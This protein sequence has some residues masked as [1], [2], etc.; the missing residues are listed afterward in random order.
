MSLENRLIDYHGWR[1]LAITNGI[2]E[3]IIPLEVGLRVMHFGFVG[4][5]NQFATFP[6]QLGQKGGEAWR[7]YGGHRLWH[8]PEHRQR[9]YSNDNHPISVGYH[10]DFWRLTQAADHVGIE[11]QMDFIP[12]HDRARV[13]VV[14]RLINR[15]AW[16]V[17]LAVWALSVMNAG[18]T[19]V[20]PLPPYGSHESNLLPKG[21]I[22]L[23][24][25]TDLADPRY[26]WGSRYALIRQERSATTPQKVGFASPQ[27]WLGYVND[28][29]LFVKHA[30]VQANAPY[31]D[32]G[33]AQEVFTDHTILELE[34]LAPLVALEPNSAT[35]H[36]ETWELF[37]DVPTPRT[38]ADVEAHILPR[39]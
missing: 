34:T 29:T 26:T 17:E 23:W 31:P 6:E 19:A 38:D 39:L 7:I 11:K 22:N 20:V 24:A 9:T 8:A 35:E 33:S 37:A 10:F 13:T 14:H 4:G 27:G 15:S 21:R 3:A 36:A 18:G 28:G 1:S 2:I 5:A 16:R 30:P 25:Y 12:D 32:F